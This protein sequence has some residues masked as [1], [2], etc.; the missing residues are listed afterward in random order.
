LS[1]KN[2]IG[3]IVYRK[4][5]KIKHILIIASLVILATPL[6][7]MAQFNP[8][9]AGANVPSA[10]STGITANFMGWILGLVGFI[11][12]LGFAASGILYLIASG[13]EGMIRH[14]KKAM[15]YSII[16]VVVS[17]SGLIFLQIG[18]IKN[19][20]AGQDYSDLAASQ[21]AGQKSAGSGS[22][23]SFKTFPAAMENPGSSGKKE[24]STVEPGASSV[25]PDSQKVNSDFNDPRK[26]GETR[27]EILSV[28]GVKMMAFGDGAKGILLTG[29]SFPNAPVYIYI[30]SDLPLIL[31][32]ITDSN[33]NWS[34]VLESPLGD[35]KHQVF[36]A[37]TDNS[38]KII[39]KSEPLF[40]VKTAEAITVIPPAEASMLDKTASPVEKRRNLD[41]IMLSLI[42]AAGFVMALAAIGFFIARKN[43]KTKDPAN[44]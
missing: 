14:A 38:G 23:A 5:N 21:S 13:D 39:A 31:S 34:Y 22:A 11:G 17:I 9:P 10:S 33:G 32:T 36:V 6:L 20:M 2:K 19:E 37:V 4:K 24:G 3:G 26:S 35:G 16:G 18:K 25:L 30:Y 1:E 41:M 15:K 27:K 28:S 29:R 40:F 8:L 42:I 43:Q 44:Q 12:V 7:A